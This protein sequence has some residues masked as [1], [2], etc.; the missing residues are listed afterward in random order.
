[1]GATDAWAGKLDGVPFHIYARKEPD[2]IMSLLSTYGTNQR[3]DG[4]ETRRDWEENG[5]NKTTM[6]NHPEVIVNHFRYRHSVDD[7]NAKR[8]SPISW[9]VVSAT[10]QWQYRVFAF[11]LSI[12]EAN[13]WLAECC[14][15]KQ[16]TGSM[17][18][19]RKK[20]AFEL[21]ENHY[22]LEEEQKQAED[23]RNRRQSK[24]LESERGHGL[25]SLPPNKKF[26]DG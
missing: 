15:T 2:Y 5:V 13:C 20:M 11:L 12:T 23:S 18:D 8:H 3:V 26:C 10:K 24:R 6:F 22:I 4:K 7:H 25:V 19:F 17:L 14:F 21:I 16:K 1:M 9:E